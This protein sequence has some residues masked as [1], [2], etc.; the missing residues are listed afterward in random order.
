MT[1]IEQLFL[2]ILSMSLGGSL[3]VG[4]V[5]LLRFALKKLPKIYA[6]FLWLI[7][8]LRFLCPVTL[9][10]VIGLIPVKTD[11]L[12]YEGLSG[13]APYADTGI[14]ALDT[15][16]TG[17]VTQY[18]AP[19]EIASA[20]P[21]QIYIWAGACLWA[22][23]LIFLMLYAAVSYVRLKQKVSTAT[24]VSDGIY[25]TDQIRTPFLLGFL[26]PG[27]YLP[28]GLSAQ[29]QEYV[30]RHELTHLKRRDYLIKPLAFLAVALH[31]FNPL[32]WL[33]FY[34]LTK[35]MEMSV[36]ETVMQKADSD[37][38]AE[39]SKSLLSLSLKQSGML[40]PL[41][42]G[43]SNTKARVKNVLN[44][45]K[46]S[47]W[48]C[49]AAAVLIVAA[50]LTLL[51]TAVNDNEDPL[52]TQPGQTTGIAG[53]QE[54]F[55]ALNENRTPYIGSN[56][57]VAAL[58][59]ALPQPDPLLT[60]DHIELL[61]EQ[62]P[63][64][65]SIF[66]TVKPGTAVADLAAEE[67]EINFSN[68]VFLFAA[69]ENMGVCN[70]SIQDDTGSS[71]V[72]YEREVLEKLFETSL[73]P[74]SESVDRL[75]ELNDKINDYLRFTRDIK[76]S[77]PEDPAFMNRL[78]QVTAAD[79][80]KGKTTDAAGWGIGICLLA[81]LPKYNISVY[82]Y[83]D[84]DYF[85]R[86]VIVKMGETLNYFDIMYNDPETF[87]VKADYCDYDKDGDSELGL[88]VYLGGGTGVSIEQLFVM[89][90][91][92]KDT[93][94]S[95]EF[96]AADYTAQ[97]KTRVTYRIDQP[98]EKLI[99]SDGANK[100]QEVDLAWLEAEGMG[101]KDVKNIC[102]GDIVDFAVTDE[103]TMDIAPGMQVGDWVSAVYEGLEELHAT[104]DYRSDG[105]FK[106]KKIL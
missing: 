59:W 98:A 93:L 78:Q 45:K 54:R 71:T 75:S 40:I 65:L 32:A 2:K 27:I 53:L 106:L 79:L 19:L 62:E 48:I 82:G 74:C 21:M 60:Y 24:F 30:I 76:S 104:I 11:A 91:I 18:A 84:E 42:F 90:E 41:A 97:I 81:E 73:Y 50:A 26:K 66:Y 69:I 4:I 34:L 43:E 63:Y 12:T 95:H 1:L 8:F 6:Y 29:E 38:R 20:N 33:S 96:M 55:A 87:P 94:T 68:A 80:A 64:E 92:K 7:V 88:A 86:G 28:A 15:A 5:L 47:G 85:K 57:K 46:P 56:S 99:L 14:H 31:W 35:D 89:E 22:T 16:V 51:T 61:T 39:Y 44:F 67:A 3:V 105:T 101:I 13:M 83:N 70:I 17:S 10:S 23:A 36:D 103:L 58:V 102:Y 9:Q 100:L 52:P 77:N 49:V 37:I 72:T 25:Q